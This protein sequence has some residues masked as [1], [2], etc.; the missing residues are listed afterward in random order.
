MSYSLTLRSDAA[1]DTN[2]F[3][4]L[5]SRN[6]IVY[7]VGNVSL[8]YIVHL[9][10]YRTLELRVALGMLLNVVIILKQQRLSDRNYILMMQ[11]V[12]NH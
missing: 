12:R 9:I 7:F 5:L 6:K 1:C 10:L 2:N 3:L 8:I 4:L 11:Q